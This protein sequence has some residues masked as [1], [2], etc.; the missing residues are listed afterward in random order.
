MKL[1]LFLLGISMFW[2]GAQ[3]MEKYPD[4]LET[5][6]KEAEPAVLAQKGDLFAK[7]NAEWTKDRDSYKFECRRFGD[8]LTVFIE[9]G[10]N[11]DPKLQK[12]SSYPRKY[13]TSVNLMTSRTIK[14]LDGHEPDLNGVVRY[15]G[16]GV[17]DE[18][19][20]GAKELEWTDR[21][22]KKTQTQFFKIVPSLPYIPTSGRQV[23]ALDAPPPQQ[24]GGMSVMVYSGGPAY[25]NFRTENF[26]RPAEDDQVRFEGTAASIFVP[27]GMGQKIYDA[28][29]KEIAKPQ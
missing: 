16:T 28:I 9:R 2:S 13:V 4:Y 23:F 6:A 25:T 12:Y 7:A 5:M 15:S 27:A 1:V 24:N 19:K 11:P 21:Y 26:V 22:D 20:V 10:A 3:A 29:M 14:L 8:F 18:D 17:P